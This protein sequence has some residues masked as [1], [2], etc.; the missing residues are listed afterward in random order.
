MARKWGWQRD[1]PDHRDVMYLA[2]AMLHL[3]VEVDL[4]ATMPRP[5]DQGE[6]GS[7][8]GNAI[9]GAVQFDRRKLGLEDWTPSRLLIYYMEREI[10][11]TINEDAGAR[12][13]DGIKAITKKGTAPESVWPYAISRFADR[14]PED[15]FDAAKKH[16]VVGYSRLTQ[17]LHDMRSCLASGYPFV[18]GFSVFESFESDAVAESGIVP[19][20]HKGESFLGGHA[21][22][23]CG[24]RDRERRFI[25]R[26]SWG[27]QWGD[28]GY[29]Y[30]PYEY[31]E[32]A[33]LAA[34]FWTVR[35]TK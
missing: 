34:D 2:P 22:L 17:S 10:E 12:I 27:S 35:V 28:K 15:V 24:Y 30:F 5:Y 18:F 20:P 32:H 11:G 19:L 21:V 33:G 4:R 9:A 3:P 7:C 26:N 16:P 31:I 23:G 13:R 8:T 6:L 1:L 25:V 14:P 29:C